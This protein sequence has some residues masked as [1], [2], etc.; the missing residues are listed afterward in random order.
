MM[1]VFL[2]HWERW[3]PRSNFKLRK[4]T[5]GPKRKVLRALKGETDGRL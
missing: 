1:G 2:G 5:K 4:K 3:P